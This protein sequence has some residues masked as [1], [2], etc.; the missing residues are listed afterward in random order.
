[1]KAKSINRYHSLSDDEKFKRNKKNREM[2]DPIKK[3]TYFRIYQNKR[4]KVDVN[5]RLSG[6]LR[7]RIR[8]AIKRDKAT[9]SLSTTKLVGCTI[10]ELK[11]HLELKFDSKM[12]WKN[13]GNWHVDHIVA[14]TKFDLTNPEEQKKCFH[15][16]NLQPLWATDNLRKSNN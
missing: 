1:M 7:A 16:T 12:S 8:A 13:Y 10:K 2:Q 14:V 5:H 11:K 3:R 9:K 6:S 15:Y 4:N